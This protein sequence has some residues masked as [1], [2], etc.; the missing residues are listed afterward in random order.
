MVIAK[1][2]D[3]G[4]RNAS[5]HRCMIT[6]PNRMTFLMDEGRHLRDYYER[7][8]QRNEP[9]EITISNG[10]MALFARFHVNGQR[11]EIAA[12]F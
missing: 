4:V 7:A 10:V 2:P 5:I 6:G 1:D 3:T 8:E 12:V 11:E 9:L